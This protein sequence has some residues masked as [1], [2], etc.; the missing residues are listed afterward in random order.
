[1][2]LIEQSKDKNK[3]NTY[4]ISSMLLEGIDELLM[5]EDSP[6]MLGRDTNLGTSTREE[7]SAIIKGEIIYGRRIARKILRKFRKA[8][9]DI[10]SNLISQ[11]I[12]ILYRDNPDKIDEARV[13]FAGRGYLSKLE[14]VFSLK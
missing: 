11:G 4:H 8:G 14:E 13:T 5:R 2:T 10:D 3:I 6:E 9:M 7:Q 12:A 1:M